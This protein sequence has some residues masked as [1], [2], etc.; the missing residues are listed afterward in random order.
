MHKE[1]LKT[2]IDSYN[3][4]TAITFIVYTA[5]GTNINILATAAIVCHVSSTHAVYVNTFR[6]DI[7]EKQLISM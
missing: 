2:K 5:P 6:H 4:K 1:R 3:T 7:R